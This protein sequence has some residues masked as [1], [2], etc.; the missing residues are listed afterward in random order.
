M[1]VKTGAQPERQATSQIETRQETR[2]VD[3]GRRYGAIGIASVA[4]AVRYAGDGKNHA[5][6][7]VVHRVEA[8]FMEVAAA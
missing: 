5:Y 6:A 7:P 8:R 4:A 2:N 1:T 3:L